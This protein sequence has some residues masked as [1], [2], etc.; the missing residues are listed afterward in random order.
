[1]IYLNWNGVFKF[2][3]SLEFF[4]KRYV[5]SFRRNGCCLNYVGEENCNLIIFY[6]CLCVFM[7]ML[8]S[9]IG[10]V[11]WVERDLFIKDIILV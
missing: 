9:N 2:F 6:S 7:G 3:F 5:F 10:K 11:S 8:I 4:F 1:M